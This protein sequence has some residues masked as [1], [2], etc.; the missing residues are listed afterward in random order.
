[1]SEDRPDLDGW[2]QL[3]QEP[4][5]ATVRRGFDRD[6]VRDHWRRT[7]EHVAD[8]E[9]RLGHA[10][11]EIAEAQRELV[12][13]RN[14]HAETRLEAEEARRDLEQVR[15]ELERVRLELEEARRERDAEPPE[16]RDPFEAVS[17]HVM[18]LVRGFDRDIE[19][20][21][22]KA[23]F[24]A[25]SILA[26]ARTEA[27]KARLA[28]R[29]EEE[30]ARA[31]SER[32]LSEARSEAA[33]VRAELVPLREVTLSQAQAVRDRLRVS[34]VELEGLMAEESE[35]SEREQVIVL[36][37]TEQAEELEQA[38]ERE[39]PTVS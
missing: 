25:S 11:R 19:R 14:E 36:G 39:Q 2:T 5:F 33:S 28:A 38:G 35:G 9:S 22:T 37:R 17:E 27:A 30:A 29:H 16:A 31:E 26:E 21:R 7:E 32:M 20:I 10:L 8:L 13:A 34:L 23:Q 12:R 4:A 18:D 1:M 15:G 6:Q 24:E 3:V